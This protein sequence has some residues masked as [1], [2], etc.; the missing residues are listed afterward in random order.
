MQGPDAQTKSIGTGPFVFKEWKQGESL[1]FAKNPN[2]WE[3]GKPYIDGFVVRVVEAQ[4][5][6]VQLEAG[7][8]DMV[9]DRSGG[10]HRSP[11]EG[12]RTS[13][14]SSIRSPGRS[15]SSASTPRERRMTT[16]ACARRSN[17][18]I[19]RQRYASSIMQGLVKPL[20]LF[21][22]STSPAFDDAKNASVPFDLDKAQSLLKEAG[23]SKLAGGPAV[24]PG[25][26]SGAEAAVARCT[27]RTW[28]RSA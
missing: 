17:Y 21:W 11:Q 24:H 22:S 28:P 12:S 19:D 23:V 10:R 4:S 15:T 5:A 9:Q 6:L 8:V 25:V 1:T 2:Y 26:L 13:R 3:S 18:A 7:A 14:S 20:T 27:R 16:S